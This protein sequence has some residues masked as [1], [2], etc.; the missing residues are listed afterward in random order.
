[1]TLLSYKLTIYLKIVNTFG[2]IYENTFGH[3]IGVPIATIV[4]ETRKSISS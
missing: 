4:I 2:R 3:K 1:M